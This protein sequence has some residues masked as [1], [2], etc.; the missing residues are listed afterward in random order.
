MYNKGEKKISMSTWDACGRAVAGL[1]SLSVKADATKDGIGLDSW[2]NK[3]LY[4]SLFLV[5]QRDILESLHCVLG[6]T[7]E[8]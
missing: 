7:D 1:L 2:R 8:D 5:S 4:I 3:G 6:T